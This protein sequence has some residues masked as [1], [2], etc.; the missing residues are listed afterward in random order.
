MTPRSEATAPQT[1]Q[2]LDITLCYHQTWNCRD[3][4]VSLRTWQ[5]RTRGHGLVMIMMPHGQMQGTE[6]V[7]VFMGHSSYSQAVGVQGM[8]SFIMMVSLTYSLPPCFESGVL[9]RVHVL[10]A[11][12]MGVTRP[13]TCG[14]ELMRLNNKALRA[15]RNRTVEPDPSQTWSQANEAIAKVHKGCVSAHP[16]WRSKAYIH[17]AYLLVNVNEFIPLFTVNFPGCSCALALTCIYRSSRAGHV[18]TCTC[19]CTH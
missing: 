19:T 15:S 1:P 12:H 9:L 4:A 11:R 17:D 16:Q 18:I 5:V 8:R 10:P 13:R 7:D 6:L 2:K 14:F 3:T